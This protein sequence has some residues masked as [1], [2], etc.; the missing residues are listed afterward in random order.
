MLVPHY[1]GSRQLHFRRR[2]W[3]IVWNASRPELAP[4]PHAEKRRCREG[5]DHL[6]TSFP[7]DD[8]LLLIP[9]GR[10]VNSHSGRGGSSSGHRTRRRTCRRAGVAVPPPRTSSCCADLL[11]CVKRCGAGPL[12]AEP[13][14]RRRRRSSSAPAESCK[15]CDDAITFQASSSL[16]MPP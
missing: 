11:A 16:I 14:R 5:R 10:G 6:R 12:M 15:K 13:C 8:H 3:L 2:A 7:G 1:T 4:P 9:L